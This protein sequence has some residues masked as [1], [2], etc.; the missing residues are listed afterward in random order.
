LLIGFALSTLRD[1]LKRKL[2]PILHPIRNKTKSNRF[3]P[4]RVFPPLS[5]SSNSSFDWLT[6]LSTFV[7][8]LSDYFGFCF[9]TVD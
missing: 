8:G 2:V 5:A 9:A 6:V 7:I 3:A 1:W 4:A